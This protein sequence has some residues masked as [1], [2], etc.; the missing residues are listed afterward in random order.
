MSKMGTAIDDAQVIIEAAEQ[1]AAEI[2]AEA[3]RNFRESQQRGYDEGFRQGK[4]EASENAVRLLSETGALSDTLAIEAAQLALAI[5][6]TILGEHIAVEP[7]TVRR[8]AAKALRESV[9]GD[10]AVILV[11]PDDVAVITSHLDEM[12]RISGGAKI[13]IESDSSIAKGGCIVRTDFGEVDATI[14]TLVEAISARF[15]V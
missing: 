7:D 12:R 2:V 1:R 8:I 13:G 15:G 9:V 10:A 14:D 3:E 4:R 11:N 5:C 6:R